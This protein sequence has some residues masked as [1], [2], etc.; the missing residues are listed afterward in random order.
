MLQKAFTG[1]ITRS[2]FPLIHELQR[3]V[4]GGGG[5]TR[6]MSVLVVPL[7]AFGEDRDCIGRSIARTLR[8]SPAQAPLCWRTSTTCRSRLPTRLQCAAM[9]S[10]AGWN[11]RLPPPAARTHSP[12]MQQ[13][14]H[15]LSVPAQ[16][17][18]EVQ[19]HAAAAGQDHL[20]AARLDGR[21]ALCSIATAAHALQVIFKIMK[22]AA[23]LVD[24]ERC[25]WHAVAGG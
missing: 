17:R 5:S 12:R 18:C 15:P 4:Y 14:V 8:P 2:S 21:R 25:V 19:R 10:T 11:S 13:V 3:E 16:L 6:N 23:E 24:C 22:H 9:P 1:S 7:F 20:R